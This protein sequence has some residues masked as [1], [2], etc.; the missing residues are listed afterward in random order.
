MTKQPKWKAIGRIGDVNPIDHDGG[1]VLIDRTGVYPPEMEVI[2]RVLGADEG[3]E[4][5]QISRLCFDR[6]PASE[7]YAR[8]L[9]SVAESCGTTSA[10]LLADLTS[11]DV[12]RAARGYECLT[13][14]FGW[15]EFDQYPRIITGR[16]N[17]P[18]RFR[19]PRAGL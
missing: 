5:W 18:R 10:E 6:D 9:P 14:Y 11:A 3:R 4:Q 19:R 16:S 8:H 2:H 15:F 1:Y 7:W 12:M 17:L 13:D